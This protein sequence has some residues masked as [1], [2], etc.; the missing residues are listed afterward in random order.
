MLS[1][2]TIALVHL[3]FIPFLLSMILA[4]LLVFC[5]MMS[6]SKGARCQRALEWGLAFGVTGVVLWF[7]YAVIFESG[8]NLAPAMSIL[9]S[10]PIGFL[11][12]VAIGINRGDD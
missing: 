11:I 4:P 3:M 8:N 2:I 10:G 5:V 7:L 1:W 12:G 6:K 9:V